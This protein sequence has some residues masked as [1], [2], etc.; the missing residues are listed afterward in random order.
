MPLSRG[1]M[2]NH[3][4]KELFSRSGSRP[5]P[6]HFLVGGRRSAAAPLLAQV[7][8]G[9]GRTKVERDRMTPQQVLEELRKG[10]RFRAGS[11]PARDYRHQQRASAAGQ[12]PAAVTLG[13]HEPCRNIFD[14]GIGDIAHES[15]A[16][17]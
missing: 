10:G 7:E 14:V 12:F 1:K 8:R 4:E 3:V 17:S 11:S 13:R 2:C 6:P 9:E 15:P 16:T 5:T